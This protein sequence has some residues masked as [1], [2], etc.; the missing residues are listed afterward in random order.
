MKQVLTNK[1]LEKTILHGIILT[2]INFKVIIT[3]RINYTVTD[4]NFKII[5]ICET[6]SHE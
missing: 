5:I 1:N 6:S 4:K 3:Y 2:D